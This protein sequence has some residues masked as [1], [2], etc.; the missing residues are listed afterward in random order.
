[1]VCAVLPFTHLTHSTAVD[2]APQFSQESYHWVLDEFFS[3][4]Y[5]ANIS[6]TT[7]GNHTLDVYFLVDGE[8]YPYLLYDSGLI[9]LF[10]A[11]NVSISGQIVA[12]DDRYDCVT[13]AGLVNGPCTSTVDFLLDFGVISGCPSSIVHSSLGPVPVSWPLAVFSLS[14]NAILPLAYNYENNS[15]FPLGV[16]VVTAVVTA[17]DMSQFEGT[18]PMCE[19]N[20]C[21]RYYCYI[22]L[23]YPHRFTFTRALR[24]KWIPFPMYFSLIRTIIAH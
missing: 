9:Y 10:T 18:L 16:T 8:D 3:D 17:A 19:F 14:G 4:G 12:H 20:V 15:P 2:E 13:E 23:T 21:D 1:M 22:L 24:L 11:S 6:V 5:F 7:S